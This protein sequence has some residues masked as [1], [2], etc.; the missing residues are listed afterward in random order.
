MTAPVRRPRGEGAGSPTLHPP[1]I[2]NG[3]G[4]CKRSIAVRNTPHRYGDSHAI[5]GITRKCCLPYGRCG[6]PA[7]TPTESGTRFS[8]PGGMRG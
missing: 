6:I 4:E 5:Y 3:K 7:F 1:L 8:D 2:L